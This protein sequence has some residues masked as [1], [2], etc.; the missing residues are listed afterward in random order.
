[1]TLI[2]LAL[3]LIYT[4]VLIIKLCDGSPDICIT[5]G[6]SDANGTAHTST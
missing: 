3:I 6:F 1:M 4:C 2:M 5:F